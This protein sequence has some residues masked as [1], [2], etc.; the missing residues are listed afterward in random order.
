M[1]VSG[2]PIQAS[3]GDAEE[4]ENLVEQTVAGEDFAPQHR[5]GDR[6]AEE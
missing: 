2:S 3:A 6:A 1:A 4:G 5:D